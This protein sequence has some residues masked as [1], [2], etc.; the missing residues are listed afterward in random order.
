VERSLDEACLTRLESLTIRAWPRGRL[1]PWLD[2][3]AATP[4][5][6]LR[7][8]L[9]T[10][11]SEDL[12]FDFVRLDGASRRSWGRVRITLGPRSE[13]HD[14]R[15]YLGQLP[16]TISIEVDARTPFLPG[17]IRQRAPRVRTTAELVAFSG[18]GRPSP[19]V[20]VGPIDVPDL[21]WPM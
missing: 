8:E 16:A 9:L 11:N 15:D 13:H 14:V 10:N 12:A 19:K 4:L 18:P 17:V 5:R 1:G 3:F 21:V 2:L 6:R 7:L 20:L